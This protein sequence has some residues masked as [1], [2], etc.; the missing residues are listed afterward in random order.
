MTLHRI[1]LNWQGRSLH[2]NVG[3]ILLL[4]AKVWF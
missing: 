2:S 1:F 4:H 3:H